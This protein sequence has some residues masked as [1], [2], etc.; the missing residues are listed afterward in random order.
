MAQYLSPAAIAQR[1]HRAVQDG[2]VEE[3]SSMYVDPDKQAAYD[4]ARW[5]LELEES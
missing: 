3:I 5:D 1:H 2:K 4:L